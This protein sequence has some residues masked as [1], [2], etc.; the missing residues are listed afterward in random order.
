[1]NNTK[2]SEAVHTFAEIS[3]AH[4]CAEASKD[5]RLGYFKEN[6]G[7]VDQ[8]VSNGCPGECQGTGWMP[9]YKDEMT[10]A[11]R[12]LWIQAE[13]DAPSEDGWHMVPCPACSPVDSLDEHIVKRGNDFELKSKKSGKNLGTYTSKKGAQKREGEVEYFKGL[14]EGTDDPDSPD[15]EDDDQGTANDSAK[16]PEDKKAAS[17]KKRD[18]KAKKREQEKL[19]PYEFDN[20]KDAKKAGAHLGVQGTHLASGAGSIYRPGGSEQALRNAVAT[21][22]A[23][24]KQKSGKPVN[25]NAIG[26]VDMPDIVRRLKETIQNIR[27]S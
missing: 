18:D 19:L 3:F 13:F 7:E 12:S 6:F 5:K 21:K 17:K 4:Y 15:N 11:E 26:F 2:L 10:P 25:E 8:T 24:Q 9:I 1:M 14:K 20:D 16:S 27:K 22:K 23:K